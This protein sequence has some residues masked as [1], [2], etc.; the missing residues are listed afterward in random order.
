[1]AFI[2]S[3]GILIS[4][5]D[6]FVVLSITDLM[7]L[8]FAFVIFDCCLVVTLRL[9]PPLGYSGELGVDA[10]DSE[11]SSLG[12]FLSYLLGDSGVLLVAMLDRFLLVL[13]SSRSGSYLSLT[14]SA[15]RGERPSS[16]GWMFKP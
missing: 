14:F 15:R 13:A 12:R 5:F 6:S 2:Y 10:S 9:P 16:R 11:L 4:L 3:L 7:L 8:Y 1:M